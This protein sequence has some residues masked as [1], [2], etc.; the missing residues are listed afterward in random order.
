MDC[1]REAVLARVLLPLVFVP[2]EL[3]SPEPVPDVDADILM[4]FLRFIQAFQ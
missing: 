4:L 1:V 3:P 2:V